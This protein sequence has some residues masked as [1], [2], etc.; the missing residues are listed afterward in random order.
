MYEIVSGPV[1]E[2]TIVATYERRRRLGLVRPIAPAFALLLILFILVFTLYLIQEGTPASRIGPAVLIDGLLVACF[3]LLVAA[4]VAARRGQEL[5][6]TG[7]VIVATDLVISAFAIFWSLVLGN[8]LDPIMLVTFSSITITIVLAGTLGEPWMIVLTVIAAN[9]LTLTLLIVA[10]PTQPLAASD[11]GVLRLL[12]LEKPLFGPTLFIVQWALGVLMFVTTASHRR[13]LA[14]IGAAYIRVQQLDQLDQLKDQFI[15]NVNHELRNPTMA[16]QGYVE[17]LRVRHD[18]I[19]SER[20]AELIEK[21][22]HA[23]DDLVALLTSLLDVQR[24]DTNAQ[25]FEPE[26]VDLRAALDDAIGLIDPREGNA[27]ERDLQVRIPKGI[28]VWGEQVRV[29]QIL[30]NLLSNALKYSPSGTPVEI[31]A[32]RITA[33]PESGGGG[34]GRSTDDRQSRQMVELS[35]RDLGLGIPPEQIPLLFKRFVR[36][37]RDL[38]SNVVGNGLGL[39]LCRVLAD[40]MGGTIWVESS[41]LEGEGSTFYVRL[42]TPPLPTPQVSV[43]TA[44]AETFTAPHS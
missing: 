27:N 22:V 35:V 37:P 20:R 7:G 5:L 19:T 34:V 36:L 6:A 25:D 32:R 10:A 40:A 2:S 9:V 23:G 26:V 28:V 42:L 44:D 8:G 39:H 18:A 13:T 12:D 38:A 43:R 11:P 14:D 16:L 17:L 30:T 41:G 3:G 29:R 31:A 33:A 4:A 15:T 24:L 21:A 1:S